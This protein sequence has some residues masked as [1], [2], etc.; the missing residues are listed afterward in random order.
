MSRIERKW[1]SKSL[2][3]ASQSV[4]IS[5]KS[6]KHSQFCEIWSNMKMSNNP[7]KYEVRKQYLR[8]ILDI[9]EIVRKKYTF[10]N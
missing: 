3:Q 5:E 6:P 8:S 7:A 4:L 2:W 1:D 9:S 10:T